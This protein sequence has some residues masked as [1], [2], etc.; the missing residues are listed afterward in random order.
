MSPSPSPPLRVKGRGT[1]NTPPES[2]KREQKDEGP[3]SEDEGVVKKGRGRFT[4]EDEAEGRATEKADRR[5]DGP[6]SKSK[7]ARDD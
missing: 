1:R 2:R 7:W 5:L 3:K 4:V 6:V